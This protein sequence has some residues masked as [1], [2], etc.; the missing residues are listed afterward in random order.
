MN[1]TPSQVFKAFDSADPQASYRLVVSVLSST[2]LPGH[3]PRLHHYYGL[4]CHLTPHNSTLESPLEHCL[5]A[6]N[7]RSLSRG[8]G[9]ETMPGFPS[10]LW[11]PEYSSILNH[12]ASRYFAHFKPKA[13]PLRSLPNRRIRFACAMCRTPSMA[14]FRPHRWPVTPLPFELPSLWTGRHPFL[15]LGSDPRGQQ[16]G[17]ASYAGRT[18]R[19]PDS[20]ARPS[21][22]QQ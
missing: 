15:P 18:K 22:F 19:R 17:F 14:S 11:L 4:I 3:R 16:T 5:L 7:R 2:P 10:Y 1:F 21:F 12:R 9:G 8:D 13:L 20:K 6:P